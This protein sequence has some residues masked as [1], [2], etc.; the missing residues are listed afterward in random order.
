ME[1]SCCPFW[2]FERQ[3]GA[4]RL[5]YFA[6]SIGSNLTSDLCEVRWSFDERFHVGELQLIT[7]GLDGFRQ[8]R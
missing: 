4:K 8:Q 6:R 3:L 1:R 2:I 7:H 5:T